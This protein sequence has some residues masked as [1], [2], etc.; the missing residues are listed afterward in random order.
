MQTK[1]LFSKETFRWLHVRP[2]VALNANLNRSSS[3]LHK[4]CFV[5]CLNIFEDLRKFR[6]V[7][8]HLWIGRPKPPKLA[9]FG[10]FLGVRPSVLVH[11]ALVRSSSILQKRRFVMCL[12]QCEVL[13]K[14]RQVWGYFFFDGP[15]P[16]EMAFLAVYFQLLL[17]DTRQILRFQPYKPKR[18]LKTSMLTCSKRQSSF[19]FV[20]DWK[21]ASENIKNSTF[22]VPSKTCYL[23]HVAHRCLTDSSIPAIQI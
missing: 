9:V 5:M 18:S 8:R 11:A 4:I 10:T 15:R 21:R 16:L 20:F 12:N 2:S 22:W 14:F 13:R 19:S 17:S 7:W 6:Q 1:I 23:A 3:N